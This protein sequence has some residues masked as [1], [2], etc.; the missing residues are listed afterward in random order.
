MSVRL[1]LQRV[2]RRNRAQYRVVA[3]DKRR[4]RDGK[5]IEV[6][7]WYDPHESS[8]VRE[9]LNTERVE[10]WISVGAEVS[11]SVQQIIKRYKKASQS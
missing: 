1:R 2:G 5:S 10:H 11:D 8:G 4:P 3:A 7:G 6:L 9:K